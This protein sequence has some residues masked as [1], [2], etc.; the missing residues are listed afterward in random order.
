MKSKFQL[1]SSIFQ[2]FIGI[3]SIASF[4]LLSSNEENMTKWIPTLIL[5]I[6]FVILGIVGIVD[7]FKQK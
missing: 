7:F 6:A 3:C 5:S 1:F 2:L 4:I